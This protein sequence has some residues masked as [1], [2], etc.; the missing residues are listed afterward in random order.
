M[1]SYNSAGQSQLP[2]DAGDPACVASRR[3]AVRVP[4]ARWLLAVSCWL[5][6]TATAAMCRIQQPTAN[7][8]QLLRIAFIAFLSAAGSQLV[9]GETPDAVYK[10][11]IEAL[12]LAEADHDQLVPAVKLL[13]KA[14]RLCEGKG[15]EEH[16]AEINSCL[17][18]AKKKMTLADT[19][20]LEKS[21]SDG[22]RLA[23]AVYNKKV[24]NG[25][26]QAWFDRAESFAK[27]HPED[28]LLTAIRYFE[29]ADRFRNS[30]AGMSAM[31]LSLKA[32]QRIGEKTS[33]TVPATEKPDEKIAAGPKAALKKAGKVFIKTD[34][35]GADIYIAQSDT[36]APMGKKTPALVDAPSGSQTFLLRLAGYSEKAL[37]V[38]VTDAILKPDL[39]TLER[40]T[41][42]TDIIFAEEGWSVFIDKQPATD[43]AGKPATTPCTINLLSGKHE[44]VL[45]KEGFVDIAQKIE[46]M[47]KKTSVK[48]EGRVT[49]GAGS[50]DKGKKN[51]GNKK[52]IRNLALDAKITVNTQAT[53]NGGVQFV[54]D[55]NFSTEDNKYWYAGNAPPRKDPDWLEARFEKDAAIKSIRMLTGIGTK[56]IAAG[57]EPFDYDISVL[58]RKNETDKGEW[59]KVLEVKNGKHPKTEPNPDDPKTHFIV[60]DLSIPV[61]VA[62]VRFSCTKSSGLNYSPCIFEFE[63]FGN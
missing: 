49:K 27:A 50:L 4:L 61:K 46:V 7:S 6:E 44:L 53:G 16:A 9:A 33:N 24:G 14:A 35:P 8:Q 54:N 3:R 31:N 55:G 58:L 12:R 20:L 15:D 28:P 63:I 18:W 60:L 45:A 30:D 25:E 10:Q 40:Q 37:N 5:L 22:A 13:A 56:R 11:G 2:S 17:Y 21:D 62:G 48:I 59:K 39:V 32:M 41:I 57:H 43:S 34:P 38:E 23:E 47:E 42:S 52:G 36:E 26:A 1:A 19:N 51:D 29:V